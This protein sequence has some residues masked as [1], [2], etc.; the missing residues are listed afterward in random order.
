MTV[1][2]GFIGLASG[3]GGEGVDVVVVETNGIGL[4][5]TAR[6]LGHLRRPHPR[7]LREIFIRGVGSNSTF[8]FGELPALNRQLAENEAESIRQFAARERVDLNRVT[9][10]GRIGPL[11]WHEAGG[12]FPFTMEA[13]LPSLIA[14]RTGLTIFGDFRERD[15]AAGGQGMPI[16]GLA[17]WAFFRDANE[18]RILVHLGSV[19]SVVVL[20]AG[21]K[22][23]DV[24]AFEAGP[25]TRLLDAV[26]RQGSRGKEN[27]DTGGKHAVQGRCLDCLLADWL[28]HPYFMQRPP[29][30]LSRAEF[31][32]DWI[33]RAAQ[34]AAAQ[35]ASLEDLLCTLTHLVVRS[36]AN[37]LRSLP[38]IAGDLRIWLSG[39]GSRNGFFWRLLEHELA[40]VALYRLD[41]LGVPAQARQAAEA[42]VLAAF[43][44]DG[45][46]AG[47]SS[48]TGEVGRILGR[49]TP[50]EARNWS[51]CLQWMAEKSSVPELTRPYKA[52]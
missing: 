50:G 32:A 2:R 34:S 15:L 45:V 36:L 25:G 3:T 30:S 13:G 19:T 24:I 5:L 40:G 49:V 52:A 16:A 42:A 6:V 35:S 27:F 22:P 39:G 33:T 11:L 10:I 18:R 12:R 4:H 29:K 7:E 21:A 17:D 28:S 14:E 23:Q 51:R 26:I 44:M 38:R 48:T 43:A 41:E 9:A 37:S 31:G 46:P 8:P 1:A 20:P 47:S